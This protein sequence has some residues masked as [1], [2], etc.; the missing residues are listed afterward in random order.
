MPVRVTKIGQRFDVCPQA[1]IRDEAVREADLVEDWDWF[2]RRGVLPNAGGRLNQ[3]PLFL[4]SI[5]VIEEEGT[6]TQDL[7]KKLASQL[8]SKAA[9]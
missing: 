3:S 1:W 8:A 5:S 4:D 9:S 2:T 6:V 7:L